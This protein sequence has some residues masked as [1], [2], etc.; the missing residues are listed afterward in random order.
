MP[1]VTPEGILGMWV[2]TTN[3]VQMLFSLRKIIMSVCVLKYWR[4]KEDENKDLTKAYNVKRKRQ[5]VYWITMKNRKGKLERNTKESIRKKKREKKSTRCKEK[6]LTKRYYK[7]TKNEKNR[8]VADKKCQ[9]SWSS[10]KSSRIH[11]RFFSRDSAGVPWREV[12][13][14]VGKHSHSSSI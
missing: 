9:M 1:K 6:K 12:R 7:L 13:Q 4:V 2:L 8:A 3:S 5:S 14:E 11:S 10:K